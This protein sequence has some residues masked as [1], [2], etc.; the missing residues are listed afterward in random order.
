MREERGKWIKN[1]KLWLQVGSK[2]NTFSCKIDLFSAWQYNAV[3]TDNTYETTPWINPYLHNQMQMVTRHIY[4]AKIFITKDSTASNKYIPANKRNKTIIVSSYFFFNLT[5]DNKDK[6]KFNQEDHFTTIT[7]IFD[8]FVNLLDLQFSFFIPSIKTDY[9][10]LYINDISIHYAHQHLFISI[11]TYLT[12]Q[13]MIINSNLQYVR[14]KN[15]PCFYI[16]N[17]SKRL[18]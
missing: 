11:E 17:V 10:I 1:V 3:K 4:V 9:L 18:P 2:D 16:Y 15:S 12:C 5:S 8:L 13:Y 14:Y 7:T 6:Q